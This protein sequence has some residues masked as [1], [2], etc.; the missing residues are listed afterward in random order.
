M[1]DSPELTAGLA[2]NRFTVATRT[3]SI[4][5]PRQEINRIRRQS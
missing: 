1:R 2:F 3:L 5:E 4:A